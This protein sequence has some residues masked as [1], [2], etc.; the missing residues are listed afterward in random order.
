MTDVEFGYRH[1]RGDRRHIVEGQTMTGMTF[2]PDRFTVRR[3]RLDA[4]EFRDLSLPVEFSVSPGMQF[5][6]RRS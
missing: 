3:G 5:H 1:D 6:D 2:E 4:G